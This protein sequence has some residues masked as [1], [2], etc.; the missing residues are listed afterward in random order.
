MCRYAAIFDHI[1]RICCHIL[2]H[3]R[4][5]FTKLPSHAIHE[6]QAINPNAISHY[7]YKKWESAHSQ[8]SHPQDPPMVIMNNAVKTPAP[9]LS[10][11]VI[12]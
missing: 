12:E 2:Y 1:K 6:V 11:V 3:T 10:A 8:M 7:N 9:A 5:L 4:Q